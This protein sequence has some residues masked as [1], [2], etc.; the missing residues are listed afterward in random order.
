ME[1]ITVLV[2]LLLFSLFKGIILFMVIVG[3][4]LVARK[5]KENYLDKLEFLKFK[6]GGS[7]N[8]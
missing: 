8:G 3:V 2:A 4:V 7:E 6:N 5:Q 1:L